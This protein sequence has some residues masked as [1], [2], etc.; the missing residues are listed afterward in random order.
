MFNKIPTILNPQEI[1]DKCFSR[2]SKVDVPYELTLERRIRNEVIARIGVIESIS[3]TFLDKIVKRFPSS[4]KLHPFFYAILDLLFD[5]DRYK[6]SLSKVDRTSRKIREIASREIN[7]VKGIDGKRINEVM[8]DFY[9]RFSSLI[10]DLGPDLAFLSAC[11]DKM[12]LVPDIN[13]ELPTFIIAGMPNS[14]KSS[15]I[16]A[17]TSAKPKVASY[18]F[19]TQNIHVGYMN[20]GYRKVQMIDTPGILDRPMKKRNDM[21]IKAMLALEKI[22]GVVLFLFDY[23]TQALYTREQQESLFS[24]ISAMVKKPVIRVQSKIDI[25]N[26]REEKIAVSSV[27]GEG[28]ED[29]HEAIEASIGEI[30]AVKRVH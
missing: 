11:R 15:L 25:T 14:G 9:G 22:E 3:C 19:T 4:E 7:R 12:K 13:P 27:T 29:L 8:R 17:L 10:Y 28:I 20:I 1:I 5:V 16:S 18:P 2:A 30:N 24:E 26:V 6:I 23:S 21:E